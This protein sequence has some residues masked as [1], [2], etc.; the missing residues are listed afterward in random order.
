MLGPAKTVS[1]YLGKAAKYLKEGK[2]LA[3]SVT[4]HIMCRHA[5]RYVTSHSLDRIKSSDRI[6]MKYFSDFYIT[7]WR[8]S[9]Q[10]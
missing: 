6:S 3:K 8:V 4:C 7:D 2:G 10:R 9:R 5:T 1:E